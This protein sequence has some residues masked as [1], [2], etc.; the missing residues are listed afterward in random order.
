MSRSNAVVV[1]NHICLTRKRNGVPCVGIPQW[2]LLDLKYEGNLHLESLEWK[3]SPL[4]PG[5]D[6]WS[7]SIRPDGIYHLLLPMCNLAGLSHLD[8][9]SSSFDEDREPGRALQLS[10]QHSMAC[11]TPG[12]L[13]F[14]AV[15]SCKLHTNKCME[16]AGQI[17]GESEKLC[18][19]HCS[20][21]HLWMGKG[22]LKTLPWRVICWTLFILMAPLPLFFP[23]LSYLLA[24]STLAIQ[25]LMKLC[26]PSGL[27]FFPFRISNGNKI[28]QRQRQ[29][30]CQLLA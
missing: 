26:F 20:V 22:E 12:Q 23:P 18:R 8:T 4:L 15:K 3:S 16:M 27:I 24:L 6:F 5:P 7:W 30:R 1:V 11:H 28:L 13:A 2:S 29:L 21:S 9:N 14:P 19:N 25:W 10:Q 17:F